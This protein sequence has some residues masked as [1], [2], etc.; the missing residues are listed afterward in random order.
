M[1]S[2]IPNHIS[3]TLENEIINGHLMPGA[4]L[5]QEELAERF[6]VS[7]QPVR[8][9]LD[10]LGAKGLAERRSNRTVEVCKLHSEAG[11]E[12]LAIRKLLEPEALAA[13]MPKLSPQD[14]L[15]AKQAQERFE[16]ETT[17]A[18]LAQHD[19]DFHMALYGRCENTVLLRLI[20]DLRRLN[21]RAYLGQ[22]L[23]SQAR[24]HCIAS[25]WQLLDAVSANDTTI[26]TQLLLLH[27]D[28][29]KARDT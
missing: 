18:N 13:S 3:T 29:S 23:G 2:N 19:A 6:G 24:D 4:L 11:H 12:A 5:Q 22:P 25:H 21:Q 27:F 8:A 16:I 10:I 20:S 15:A 28:I 7:R 9:A 26:A 1:N 17:P 14:L